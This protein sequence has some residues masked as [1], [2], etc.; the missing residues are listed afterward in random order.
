MGFAKSTLTTALL[1]SALMLAQGCTTAPGTSNAE[2]PMGDKRFAAVQA[3]MTND[4]VR[5]SLGAPKRITRFP[6]SNNVAWDYEGKDTWGYMV[7]YS[8][9]FDPNG[10]VLSKLARRINDGG[11]LK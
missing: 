1:A 7:E 10:R 4:E 5:A 6:G 11:E 2:P 9:T 8:V 3:G